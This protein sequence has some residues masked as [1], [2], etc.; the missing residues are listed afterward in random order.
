MKHW[1]VG[2]SLS[3]DGGLTWYLSEEI[4]VQGK[5]F[6]A[7]HPM[8]GVWQGRNGV[9]IGDIP[10][11]PIYLGD[12]TVL[13]PVEITPVG[14]D[15]SYY[16]PGGGYTYTD[17]AVLRGR[18]DNSGRRFEWDLS[19]RV[20]IDPQLSTR[21]LDEPTLAVLPDGRVLMVMR[22]SNATRPDLPGRRWIAYSR[23]Q[24]RTWTQPQP[25][26]YSNGKSFFSPS[27]SSEL[28][29]HSSGRIFWVGNICPDNPK[30]NAPRYPII[31]G[32][33]EPASGLLRQDSVRAIDNRGPHE[34]RLLSLASPSLRE[35]RETGEIILNLTR[36]GEQ[37]T[38]IAPGVSAERASITPGYSFTASAYL[39]RIPV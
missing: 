5:E 2:Y 32:E 8:A 33:V 23:D 18:W 26:T 36:W 19:D 27:S 9:M 11:A 29:A 28:I 12:G 17:V 25:W 14:P 38:E 10:S 6:N 3:D 21:G 30:G 13:V 35:D 31:I 22:G 7:A 4:I 15:G 16:N 1:S 24:G 39:Y 34:S 20:R 37:S